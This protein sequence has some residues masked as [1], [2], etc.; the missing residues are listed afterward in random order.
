MKR[1]KISEYI[2]KDPSEL[3]NSDVLLGYQKY[4]KAI[5][6]Y[7]DHLEQINSINDRHVI[8]NKGAEDFLEKLSK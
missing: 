5:D 1:P 6:K 7:A 8:A 4:A 3:S 2:K